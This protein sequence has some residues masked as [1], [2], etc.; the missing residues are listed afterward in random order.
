MYI[1]FLSKTEADMLHPGKRGCYCTPSTPTSHRYVILCVIFTPRIFPAI[2]LHQC[3]C[4]FGALRKE[5]LFYYHLHYFPS[6]TETWQSETRGAETF[7]Y[8]YQYKLNIAYR[9]YN[10]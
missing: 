6:V 7:N 4:C 10:I 5:V 1:A 8:K 9:R 2:I 3:A